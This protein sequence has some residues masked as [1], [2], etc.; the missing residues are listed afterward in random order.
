M[1]AL[2]G[3][4]KG[5]GQAFLRGIGASKIKTTGDIYQLARVLDLAGVYRQVRLG[6][7][8]PDQHSG[9]LL[10]QNGKGGVLKLHTVQQDLMLAAAAVRNQFR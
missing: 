2:R 7:A 6:W 4:C 9:R 5:A 3:I 8:S 1:R 10:L